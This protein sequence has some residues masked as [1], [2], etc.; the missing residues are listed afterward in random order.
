MQARERTYAVLIVSLGAIWGSS[1]LLIK[2][3]VRDFEPTVV[4]MLRLLL[5]GPLLLLVPVARAGVRG[6]AAE[7]RAAW[8]PVAVLALV[9][10]A[11][12]YL[13]I[14]WGEKHVDAGVG[15]V[16]NSAVPIFVA[17][18]ALRFRR[19]ERV[20]GLRLVGLGLGLGGVA[21]LAGVHPEGGGWAVVGT[22]AIVLAALSYACAVMFA[23]SR[24]ENVR[25]DVLASGSI[26]LA[27]LLVLPA[28]LVQLPA[29]GAGAPEWGCVLA[30]AFVGTTV[31]QLV[32][33]RLIGDYGSSRTSLVS[34][35]FPAFGV[36]E[37]AL[38]LGERVT[39]GKLGGMALILA[40]VA[41]A[42]GLLRPARRRRA[43]APLA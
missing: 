34:Y 17:L 1:Y 9:N 26:V 2:V 37:G 20:I 11:V 28:A 15:A 18:L 43:A 32:Y 12:P 41:L 31:A 23:Q 14:T 19:S 25:G 33:F 30:L 36:V 35:L 42:S 5:S 29:H 39:A 8:R 6:A 40:G 4:V 16:A 22:L 38:V 3:A 7:L 27:G 10:A 24:V 13:L 21:L